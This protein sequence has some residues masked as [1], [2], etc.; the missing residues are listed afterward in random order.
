MEFQV[1]VN[2]KGLDVV[3]FPGLITRGS[4]VLVKF[5]FGSMHNILCCCGCLFIHIIL[6]NVNI[7]TYFFVVLSICMYVN[8]YPICFSEIP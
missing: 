8:W 7:L 2:E 6:L 1:P 5:Y 4:F 3:K